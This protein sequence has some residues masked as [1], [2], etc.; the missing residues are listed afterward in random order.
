MF[1]RVIA[2][3]NLAKEWILCWLGI[4]THICS[5]YFDWGT[6]VPWLPVVD[7]GFTGARHMT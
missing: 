3:V 4:V 1:Q 6:S 2:T 7:C 5:Q